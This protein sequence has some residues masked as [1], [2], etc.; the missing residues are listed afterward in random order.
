M[1]YCACFLSEELA[2]HG[3]AFQR[4]VFFYEVCHEYNQQYR[5]DSHLCYAVLYWVYE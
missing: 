1:V 2:N 3:K 4:Q 5:V